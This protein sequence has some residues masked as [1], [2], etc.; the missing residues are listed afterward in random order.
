MP[1]KNIRLL[2]FFTLY[3]DILTEGLFLEYLVHQKCDPSWRNESEHGRLRWTSCAFPYCLLF[4]KSDP[5]QFISEFHKR[6]TM[7]KCTTS[8]SQ[9]AKF[10]CY[11][12]RFAVTVTNTVFC[13]KIW[14]GISMKIVFLLNMDQRPY[15][16]RFELW[17]VKSGCSLQFSFPSVRLFNWY[18]FSIK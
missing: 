11:P 7:E 3:N 14:C 12:T 4:V 8:P 5:I 2:A 16:I 15:L 9:S 17:L 6:Q 18:Y 1:V 10:R 13:G